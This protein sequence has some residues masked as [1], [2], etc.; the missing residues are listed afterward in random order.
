MKLA[1]VC[2]IFAVY[3]LAELDRAEYLLGVL[4]RKNRLHEILYSTRRNIHIKC[5]LHQLR[6]IVYLPMV[7][8]LIFVFV[9]VTVLVILIL[10]LRVVADA[11]DDLSP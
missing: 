3:R 1:Q 9:R 8:S 7:G 4:L 2:Q 5:G 11:A 6:Q 10:V